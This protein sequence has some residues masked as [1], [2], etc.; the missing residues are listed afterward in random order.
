MI[1]QISSLLAASAVL[2]LAAVAPAQALSNRAWVSAKFGVDQLTC[3]LVTQPCRTLQYVHNNI[4]VPGGE[5]DILDPGGYGP[6]TITKA[7]SIINNGVGTSG[8]IQATAGLNAITVNAGPNDDIRL[9]GLSIQGL[10]GAA[11]G[12]QFNSGHSL[13]VSGSTISGFAGIGVQFVPNNGAGAS[14]NLSIGGG[15]VFSNGTDEIIIAPTGGTK[16][17]AALTS[18]TVSGGPAGVVVD[19]SAAGNVHLV[20]SNSNIRN[21]AGVAVEASGPSTGGNLRVAIDDSVIS[22]VTTALSSD[23]A[24]AVISVGTSALSNIATVAAVTAGGL[25]NTFANNA[26]TAFTTL[27]PLT[28]IA[29]H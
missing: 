10:N 3:A 19:A 22:N 29:P 27:G 7:L 5:I 14:S 20:I 15:S 18:C 26:V 9:E 21:I 11:N 23:G 8:V 1:K 4:I 16:A 6:V 12:I 17:N 2:S 28:T 13:G 25:V 24:N